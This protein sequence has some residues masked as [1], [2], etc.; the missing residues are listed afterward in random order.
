MSSWTKATARRLSRTT[1]SPLPKTLPLKINLKIWGQKL[2]KRLP[3]KTNDVA[4]DG[5]T[6][7]VIL[8]QAI[9]AEGMKYTTMGV[10]AM[11]IKPV[12]KARRREVVAALKD[13]AKPIKK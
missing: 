3:T 9:V 2:R 12:L 13:I 1:E 7:S 11:G 4:G 5:T 10:S 6:T 8:T